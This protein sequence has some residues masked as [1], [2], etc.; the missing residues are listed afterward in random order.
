MLAFE[1]LMRFAAAKPRYAIAN[2]ALQPGSRLM[3][4]KSKSRESY[5][6]EDRFLHLILA[7]YYVIS[8]FKITR[9]LNSKFDYIV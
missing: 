8:V 5:H 9:D 1:V 7:A 3:F 6:K 2:V 4:Y